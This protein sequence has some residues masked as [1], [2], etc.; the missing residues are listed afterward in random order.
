[1]SPAFHNL[2]ALLAVGAA[3]L[4]QIGLAPLLSISKVGFSASLPSVN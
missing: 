1:M 4:Y 3:P 2:L